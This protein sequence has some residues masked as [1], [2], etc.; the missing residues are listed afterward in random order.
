[1]PSQRD[2]FILA[3]GM[4]PVTRAYIMGNIVGPRRNGPLPPVFFFFFLIN[5]FTSLFLPSALYFSSC[6]FP[7][8]SP[9]TP[10][11]SILFSPLC[12]LPPLPFVIYLFGPTQLG[13]FIT[14]SL[15]TILKSSHQKHNGIDT[16]EM[17]A[18]VGVFSSS[19]H[20]TAFLI[21]HSGENFNRIN[22]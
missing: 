4:L 15:D 9:L 12:T 2:S 19:E 21:I 14:N 18:Y 8:C 20:F 13:T 11:C 5:R 17:L 10:I 22:C 3:A 7:L 1:M 16:H 6:L